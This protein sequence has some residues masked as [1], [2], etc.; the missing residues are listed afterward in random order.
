[1]GTCF[2]FCLFLQ[3]FVYITTPNSSSQRASLTQRC[4]HVQPRG[5]RLHWGCIMCPLI[6]PV[7]VHA[8]KEGERGDQGTG[9]SFYSDCTL[10]PR[11]TSSHTA[12]SPFGD[13]QSTSHPPESRAMNS[14]IL[15]VT[16]EFTGVTDAASLTEPRCLN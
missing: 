1:M 3:I 13:I 6:A 14:D 15:T 11:A 7:H 8:P 10:V 4:G 5:A 16:E 12:P 9:E 2:S